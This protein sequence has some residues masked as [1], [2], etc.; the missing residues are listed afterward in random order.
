MSASQ[1]WDRYIRYIGAGAV[2]TAGI[3]TLVKSIPTMIE[4]FKL[5]VGQITGGSGPAPEV[6]RTDRDLGFR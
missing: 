1:I 6:D 3:I 4:S 2:A 5:G